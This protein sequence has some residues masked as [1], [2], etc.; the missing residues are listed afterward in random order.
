[1]ES[2]GASKGWRGISPA[3]ATNLD[4]TW[5]G[6][7][8]RMVQTIKSLSV[9]YIIYT[10]YP[11]GSLSKSKP[12]FAS[13]LVV[14]ILGNCLCTKQTE[15]KTYKLNVHSTFLFLF[16][17]TPEKKICSV[18]GMA[19]RWEVNQKNKNNKSKCLRKI[20][21]KTIENI[22]WAICKNCRKDNFF[23]I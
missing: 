14:C 15:D 8:E 13:L 12:L 1:M 21:G 5:L 17:K 7:Q 11:Q 2:R 3:D 22:F 18:Q 4:G 10:L 16:F 9:G 20:H 19:A 6:V 23:L